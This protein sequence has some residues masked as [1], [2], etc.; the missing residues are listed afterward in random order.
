V[1]ATCGAAASFAASE[2]DGACAAADAKVAAKMARAEGSEDAGQNGLFHD[3]LYRSFGPWQPM[4][5]CGAESRFVPTFA[6]CPPH[7]LIG[8]GDIRK[9]ERRS[10]PLERLPLES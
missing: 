5:L 8:C 10:V 4:A 7:Q 2:A 6:I 1:Q 9:L 3:W